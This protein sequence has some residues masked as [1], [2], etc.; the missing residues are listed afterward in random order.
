MSEIS[1]VLNQRSFDGMTY[2]NSFFHFYASTLDDGRSYHLN[3]LLLKLFTLKTIE[4]SN[5]QGK[6]GC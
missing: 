4:T 2:Q 5:I 1:L 6:E 3:V